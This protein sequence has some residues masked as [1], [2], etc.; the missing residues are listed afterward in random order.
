MASIFDHDE[1]LDAA[2]NGLQKNFGNRLESILKQASENPHDF[3]KEREVHHE[4]HSVKMILLKNME[5][6]IARGEN[7][8]A[9]EKKTSKLQ[10]NAQQFHKAAKIVKTNMQWWR[11]K[12]V[13]LWIS[14]IGAA[15]IAL[16]LY[17]GVG[18]LMLH[19]QLHRDDVSTDVPEVGAQEFPGVTLKHR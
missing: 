4:V 6:V 16:A 15:V 18:M 1:L 19:H 11:W 7:L 3:E 13:V 12:V 5:T 8:S 10:E 14:I 17:Y 2:K 9:M